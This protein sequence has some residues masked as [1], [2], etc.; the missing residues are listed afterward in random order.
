MIEL[1]S[2]IEFDGEIGGVCHVIHSLVHIWII[3]KIRPCVN[4]YFINFS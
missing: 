1:E 3:P 2:E 4:A